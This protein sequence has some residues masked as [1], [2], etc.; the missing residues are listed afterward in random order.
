MPKSL[1]A[2]QNLYNNMEQTPATL[3]TTTTGFMDKPAIF[4]LIMIL[5]EQSFFFFLSI[6]LVSV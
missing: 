6:R 3:N 1:K 5:H 2:A 4:I